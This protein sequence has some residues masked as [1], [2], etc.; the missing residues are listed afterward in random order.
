MTRRH[1]HPSDNFSRRNS[2]RGL[3]G[4]LPDT[5]SLLEPIEVRRRGGGKGAADTAFDRR[6]YCPQGSG[7]EPEMGFAVA[8]GEREICRAVVVGRGQVGPGRV[9]PAVGDETVVYGVGMF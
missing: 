5:R 1:P 3:T 4:L 8:V 7:D 6:A 9:V 2:D